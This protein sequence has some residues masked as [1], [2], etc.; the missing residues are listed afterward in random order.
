MEK[1]LIQLFHERGCLQVSSTNSFHYASGLKGPIYCD[2]RLI[3]GSPELRVATLN[4]LL[5]MTTQLGL[6]FNGIM[7]MATGGIALGSLLANELELPLGY[8]RSSK[9][10]HGTGSLIEGGV[11]KDRKVLVFEDLINQGSSIQK[12]I[13]ALTQEGYEVVGV[14]S[15]VHYDF[16]KAKKYFSDKN[17]PAQ[18]AI[19]F[20][21]IV[22]YMKHGLKDEQKASQLVSWHRKTEG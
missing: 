22:D 14:L 13:D 9:K 20:G 19:W 7:A 17:I 5:R 6:D 18:S 4:H 1:S 10:A 11:P 15:I 8:V 21:D 2:N 12:G 3:L 16:S